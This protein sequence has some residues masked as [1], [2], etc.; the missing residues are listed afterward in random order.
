MAADPKYEMCRRG[1]HKPNT[2]VVVEAD[3]RHLDLQSVC[4]VCGAMLSVQVY[5]D[6]WEAVYDREDCCKVC[7]EAAP[8]CEC[9]R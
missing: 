7:E 4:T 1:K 3:G 9:D 2:D 5:S 8:Y 6:S